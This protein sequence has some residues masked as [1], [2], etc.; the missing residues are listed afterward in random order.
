[1]ELNAVIITEEVPVGFGLSA[2][3]LS[4]NAKLPD[5]EHHFGIKYGNLFYFMRQMKFKL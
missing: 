3:N 4:K 1:M 5:V 2:K